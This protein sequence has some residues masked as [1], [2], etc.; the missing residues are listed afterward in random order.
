M[1]DLTFRDDPVFEFDDVNS[2]R[3]SVH[4]LTSRTA[5]VRV[6]DIDDDWNLVAA[7]DLI[8]TPA[9]MQALADGVRRACP[10]STSLEDRKGS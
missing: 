1:S 3:V 8:V 4:R 10:G 9:E 2:R 5:I 6:E 7:I